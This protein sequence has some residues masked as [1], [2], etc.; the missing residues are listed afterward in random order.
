MINKLTFLILHYHD[1]D[2]TLKCV[3]SV[4]ALSRRADDE[5]RILVVDND[6]DLDDEIREKTKRRLTQPAPADTAAYPVHV[7][8]MESAAGFSRANNTGYRYIRE[9]YGPQSVIVCNNDITFTQ[10]D[11]LQ[12]LAR[13]RLDTPY[14]VLAPDIVRASTLEHQN[15]LDVRLRSAREAARTAR[16]NRTALGM[17]GPASFIT[18]KQIE[19]SEKKRAR[20]HTMAPPAQ[21]GIVPMGA[22]L[23]LGERFV[24]KED[25][26]FSPET[27]FFY[28]EYLLALRCRRKGYR[29]VYDPRIRVLHESGKSISARYTDRL[30]ELQF[31]MRHMAESAI[32][33]RNELLREKER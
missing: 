23:I 29:I 7:L 25:T 11:F 32:I 3:R 19:F 8:R 20:R 14:D 2:T 21:A 1:T 17:G 30:D 10:K 16:R 6:T 4:Q 28:E 33:Y 18:A 24:R 13:I 26:L 31:R 12:A 5:V 9:N 27:T 22:C 15:P